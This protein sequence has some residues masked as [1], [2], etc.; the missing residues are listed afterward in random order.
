MEARTRKLLKGRRRSAG[1]GGGD[2]DYHDFLQTQDHDKIVLFLYERYII[3]Q[4]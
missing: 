2:G 4:T 3:C 1:G